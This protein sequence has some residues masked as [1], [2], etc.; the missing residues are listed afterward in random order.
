MPKSAAAQNFVVDSSP[1]FDHTRAQIRDIFTR[2]RYN[3]TSVIRAGRRKL[4][5]R[6]IGA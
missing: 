1:G 4:D 2:R 6:K 5:A 3:A